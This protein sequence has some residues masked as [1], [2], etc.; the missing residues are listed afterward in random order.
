LCESWS[1]AECLGGRSIETVYSPLNDWNFRF[2]SGDTK[3]IFR[4]C[5]GMERIQISNETENFQMEKCVEASG[6][7]ETV[8][9]NRL[10]KEVNTLS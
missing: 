2:F 8:V 1:A 10:L 3:V 4:R 7:W 9:S 6:A 5:G